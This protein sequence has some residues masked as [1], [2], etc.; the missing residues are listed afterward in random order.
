MKRIL[1]AALLLSGCVSAD[2]FV[3]PDGRRAFSADCSRGYQSMADCHKAVRE[4]CGGD[5]EVIA[6][7]KDR[8][9]AV[10]KA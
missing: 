1:F 5:Y 3:A 4:A 9:E 2:A 6:S 7:G 8:I 10:C